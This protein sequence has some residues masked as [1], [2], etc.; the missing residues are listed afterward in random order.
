[1]DGQPT[2]VIGVMPRSFQFPTALIELWRPVNRRARLARTQPFGL[3]AGKLRSVVVLAC[4]VPAWRAAAVS[5]CK[6][7]RHE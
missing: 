2:K 3:I 1:M 6:V 4:C 5:P 7:L